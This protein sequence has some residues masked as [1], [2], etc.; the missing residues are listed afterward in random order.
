MSN[1]PHTVSAA[2]FDADPRAV[3]ER[4]KRES[5]VVCDSAGRP[6]MTV[7]GGETLPFVSPE[8]ERHGDPLTV[9]IAAESL[10]YTLERVRHLGIQ[11]TE[12]QERMTA[13]LE[14]SLP[15]RVRAFHAKF[16]HPIAHR[17]HV[18]DDDTI[19]F[20]LSLIA[21]EFFELLHAAL[22]TDGVL[23]FAEA[24]SRIRAAING[25]YPYQRADVV[26]DL[27]E[28]VD[29]LTDIDYVVEG[30]RTALGVDGSKV[31]DEVQRANMSK[32]AVYVEEKDGTHVM[33]K[34]IKP[35]KPE[36]WKA[37]DIHGVLVAQGW[38]GFDGRRVG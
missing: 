8:A 37:P 38:D 19:R 16:G 36:D 9:T 28:F 29:A 14:R 4:S 5:V 30:T 7:V 15:R 17:P 26:V 32:D 27:P 2:E 21:E 35:K 24:E 3:Y 10:G 23:E 20:R 12:L 22:K 18:P 31:L 33:G 1:A 34:R 25:P 6:S 11:R 13:M